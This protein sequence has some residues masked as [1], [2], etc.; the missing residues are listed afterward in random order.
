MHISCH[1]AMAQEDVLS[2]RVA[3]H[4]DFDKIT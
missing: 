3:K 1:R 2:L 4:H